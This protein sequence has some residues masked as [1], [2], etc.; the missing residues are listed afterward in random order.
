MLSG[1]AGGSSGLLR[2]CCVRYVC[3]L[4]V[5]VGVE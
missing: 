1:G 4:Y 5:I 2:G 3:S